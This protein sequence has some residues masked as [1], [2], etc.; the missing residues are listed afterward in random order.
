MEQSQV[1]SW[2]SN[3][4]AKAPQ[5]PNRTALRHPHVIQGKLCIREEVWEE[6]EELC[7][8][9]V[10]HSLALVRGPTRL[11][12]LFFPFYKSASSDDAHLH[13]LISL[14]PTH[15]LT[16]LSNTH[17]VTQSSINWVPSHWEEKAKNPEKWKR[18]LEE[19][20]EKHTPE[21]H[22]T[23]PTLQPHLT[24]RGSHACWLSTFLRAERDQGTDKKTR[25][26]QQL[27][28]PAQHKRHTDTH[29]THSHTH[30]H[31][32]IFKLPDGPLQ[33][34]RLAMVCLSHVF[35]THR[36]WGTMVGLAI[37]KDNKF[38]GIGYFFFRNF[39]APRFRRFSGVQNF[40]LFPQPLFFIGGRWEEPLEQRKKLKITKPWSWGI[41][42]YKSHLGTQ[43]WVA[44]DMKT[45]FDQQ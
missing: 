36:P 38:F 40:S 17:V 15:S 14:M 22:H 35:V 20:G 4:N 30:T 1:S 39:F 31:A 6:E 43:W 9:V 28:R 13:H 19:L 41:S 3:K 33:S 37:D 7:F 26:E 44:E 12:H 34:L 18:T 24:S 2:Q 45:K 10:E 32:L 8:S 42:M 16:C 11:Q 21:E 5:G 29:N 23:H 25:Q 27:Q